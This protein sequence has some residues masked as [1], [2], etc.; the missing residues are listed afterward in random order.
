MTNICIDRLLQDTTGQADSAQ[1]IL[2]TDPHVIRGC[3][4]NGY[5]LRKVM[6]GPEGALDAGTWL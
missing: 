1:S 2:K 3:P 5:A 4:Q 6:H